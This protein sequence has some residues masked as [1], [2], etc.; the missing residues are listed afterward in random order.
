MHSAQLSSS[1]A[2]TEARLMKSRLPRVLGRAILSSTEAACKILV[3][4]A[5]LGFF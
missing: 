3:C 4:S 1:Q 5:S 2:S